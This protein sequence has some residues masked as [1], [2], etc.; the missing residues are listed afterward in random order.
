MLYII[1]ERSLGDKSKWWSSLFQYVHSDALHLTNLYRWNDTQRNA[2]LIKDQTTEPAI[3]QASQQLEEW[4]G[5]HAYCSTP[6]AGSFL[7][8]S[9]YR[10][11]GP[12]VSSI[13]H[14]C[15]K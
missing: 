9:T 6:M 13:E 8:I 5:R 12:I 15:S 2:L 14:S 3:Q 11:M 4:K 1:H 10:Y 7:I